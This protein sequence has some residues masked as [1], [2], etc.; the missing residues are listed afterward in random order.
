M[1]R[2]LRKIVQMRRAI[3]AT[4]SRATLPG[5]LRSLPGAEGPAP[6]HSDYHWYP[7]AFKKARAMII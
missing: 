7:T 1:Q 2:S 4:R 6:S 5:G 3:I